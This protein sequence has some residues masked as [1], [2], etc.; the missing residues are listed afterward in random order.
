MILIQ[1]FYSPL[2]RKRLAGG[3]FLVV[4]ILPRDLVVSC[5][6]I[7]LAG[8]FMLDDLVCGSVTLVSVIVANRVLRLLF[9]R[10]TLC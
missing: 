1:L 7:F 8:L 10:V 3:A 5:L 9:S 4:K 6:A 2:P